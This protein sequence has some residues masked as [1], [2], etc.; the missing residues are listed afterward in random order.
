MT[1][2]RPLRGIVLMV[3]AMMILPI[4]DG[5][6][7]ILGGTYLPLEIIWAQ[8]CLMYL[9]LVPVIILRHG[10]GALRPRPLGVQVLRGI[11]AVT[12]IGLFYSAVR[13]IPLASTTAIF[14]LAP[15]VVT[16]LSPFV[17]N[18]QVDWRRWT[19]VIVGFLGVF[20]I[21]RPD[22]DGFN[23]G[24]LIALAG[25]FSIGLFY[26]CNRKLAAGTPA[27][28]TLA[29][30]VM[31]GAIL[32]SFAVPAVWIAPKVNDVPMIA[33]FILCALVGQGLMLASFE[34]APA[35]VVAPFQYGAIISATLFGFLVLGEFPDIWTWVGIAV[36]VTS[37]IYIA[38]REGRV[39]RIEPSAVSSQPALVRGGGN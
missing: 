11:F 6:A 18:E 27:I 35:S 13:Y 20:L 26:I 12:G 36:V 37:G 38:V 24:Y 4:K 30:S 17:L 19:A 25:G 14:F 10:A 31:I 5:M 7:K 15:L 32:L 3:S 2:T 22:L 39:K 28:V 34:H 21:L 33:G 1:V 9:L 16:A 29:H 23:R 8:F